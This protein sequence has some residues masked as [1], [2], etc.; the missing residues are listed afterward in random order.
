M[1]NN[2]EKSNSRSTTLL[3]ADHKYESAEQ[4]VC[5]LTSK[6]QQL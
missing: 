2:Y 5:C 6:P 4:A 1:K 3:G